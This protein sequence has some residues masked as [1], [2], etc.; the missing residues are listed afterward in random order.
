MLD[1]VQWLD[2][3]TV[4]VLTRLAEELPS[5][6]LLVLAT[7]RDDPASIAGTD[8]VRRRVAS[9]GVARVGVSGL[10]QNS[11]WKL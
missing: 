6:P 11:P 1:E 3:G 10:T 5:V 9:N 7:G 2:P 8:A 4:R